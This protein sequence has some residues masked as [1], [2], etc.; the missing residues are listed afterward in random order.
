MFGCIFSKLKINA[1]NSFDELYAPSQWRKAQLFG[2]YQGCYAF[3]YHIFIF[4]SHISGFHISSLPPFV[5]PIPNVHTSNLGRV[6]FRMSPLIFLLF[7]LST[8]AIE[9]FKIRQIFK[10][11]KTGAGLGPGQGGV[12]TPNHPKIILIIRTTRGGHRLAD[13]NMPMYSTVLYC[14]W[15]FGSGFV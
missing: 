6:Y 14:A 10:M 9:N 13:S 5:I 2:A 7:H 11:E 15:L 4:G 3:E 8:F 12:P 1:P